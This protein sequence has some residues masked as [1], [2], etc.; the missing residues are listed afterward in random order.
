MPVANEKIAVER[1]RRRT[2]RSSTGVAERSA[3]SPTPGVV[4]SSATAANVTRGSGGFAAP[5]RP[6]YPC[7]ARKCGLFNAMPNIKQQKKRVRIA[8]EERLENLR[9]RSSIKTLAKRLS[10]SDESGEK[11]EVE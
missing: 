7:R 6:C 9:Y 10:T 3:V 4:A 2:G 1:A 5:Q 8:A 11:S